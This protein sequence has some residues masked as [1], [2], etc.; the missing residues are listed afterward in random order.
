MTVWPLPQ[1][2]PQCQ[3]QPNEECMGK[4]I[5]TTVVAVRLAAA[6]ATT[7]VAVTANAGME[8]MEP[9]VHRNRVF[10]PIST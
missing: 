3:L 5:P 6:T 10:G 2:K 7:A 9:L 8:Y 4:A 1:P